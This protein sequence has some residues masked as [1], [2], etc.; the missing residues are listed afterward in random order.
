MLKYLESKRINFHTVFGLGTDGASVMTGRLNGLGAK[1]KRKNK[2]L[3]HVHCVA[4]RLNLA[5]S[6]AGR[7]IEHCK[8]YHST[9]HSL[10]KFYSDSSVRYDKLRELQ[11]ILR[12]KSKQITEPSSVR[13][14]SVEAAVKMIFESY[15]PIL[16]SLDNDKSPNAVGLYK[17]IANSLFVLTTAFL[18]DVLTV[19]GVLSLT[20]QK[21]SVNLSHI[22]HSVD[23]TT[24]TLSAMK[25]GSN[26]VDEVLKSLGSVTPGEKTKYKDVEITDNETLRKMFTNLRETYIDTLI[27]NLNER[28]PSDMLNILEC[29]DIIFNPSRYPESTQLVHYGAEQL[30]TL[31]KFYQD[32]LDTTRVTA[33]FLQFKHLV[34]S[35]SSLSFESFVRLLIN[36]FS[37]QFQ[38]FVTLAKFA[39]VIPVSSVPCERGFS[40]QNSLKTR[41]RNRLSPERLNTLMFIKLIGPGDSE[42]MDFNKAAEM[43]NKMKTRLN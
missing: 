8:K 20:F 6:Q 28:F 5:V 11:N 15:G 22:R 34:K 27:N 41:V 10:Y 19:I 31:C 16:L 33:H 32:L 30:D 35:Y 23:A 24:D 38:D 9:I 2:H 17:F 39:L 43:F 13:W 14:L 18:I 42:K 37:D 21:D 25:Q 3:I 7:G 40:V 4:H 26:E 29:F 36:D 12:G 1:M